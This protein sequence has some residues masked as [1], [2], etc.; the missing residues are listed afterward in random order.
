M[1]PTS[2]TG[3]G[4]ATGT[5]TLSAPAPSTGA[6]VSLA[7]NAGVIHVPASVT[8]PANATRAKFTATT[9]SGRAARRGT[10]TTSYPGV[11]KTTTL[12]VNRPA[13]AGVTLSASP[14]SRTVKHG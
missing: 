4:S 3:G 10:I 8:V 7:S 6:V 14:S 12:T 1:N 5:V 2:G 11:D 13:A 9:D